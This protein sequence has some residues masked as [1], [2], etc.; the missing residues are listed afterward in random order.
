MADLDWWAEGR[1]ILRQELTIVLE[2]FAYNGF[3]LDIQSRFESSSQL[4]VE[5]GAT[6]F[7]FLGIRVAKTMSEQFGGGTLTDASVSRRIGDLQDGEPL[8]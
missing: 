2:P 6:H 8:V 3:A 4:P 5:L 1:S 7:G